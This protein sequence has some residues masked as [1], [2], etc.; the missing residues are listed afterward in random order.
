M[1]AVVVHG[2]AIAHTD[3]AH[4][5]RNSTSHVNAGLHCV[6][7]FVEVVM[8]RNNIGA[9]IDDGDQRALQLLVGQTIGFE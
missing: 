7:D 6:S 1:H 9:G 8:T 3:G 2:D 5:E 4:L